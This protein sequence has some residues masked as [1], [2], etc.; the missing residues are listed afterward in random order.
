MIRF[1]KSFFSLFL[2][3]FLPLKLFGDPL[4]AKMR[5]QEVKLFQVETAQKNLEEELSSL[6]RGQ[7][8]IKQEWNGRF[9]TLKEM[10]QETNSLSQSREEKWKISLEE[11]QKGLLSLEK[12][13]TTQREE[14]HALKAELKKQN[15]SLEL[16]LKAL[17]EPEPAS[18]IDGEGIYIVKEGDSLG[19]IARMH[20][21]SIQKI[22]DLNNLSSDAIRVGQ[23]LSIPSS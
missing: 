4:Q 19:K 1:D 23:K 12:E 7:D 17:N 20:K 6:E 8:A 14:L 21:T 16:I 2:F 10:I 22:K 5:T 9:S 3:F 13:L 11:T 15:R 18:S